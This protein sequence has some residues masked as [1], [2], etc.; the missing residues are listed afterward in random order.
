MASP[1]VR[2]ARPRGRSAS[3]LVLAVATVWIVW[4]STFLGIRVMVETIPPLLGSAVRFVLGG[5][6][7]ALVVVAVHGRGAFRLRADEW[8]GSAAM[9]LLLVAGGVGL[10]AL[11][12]HRGLPSSLAALIASSEAAMVLGLRIVAG[13]ERV[14]PATVVGVGVGVVGVVLLLSPG[15]RPAGVTLVAALLGLAGSITW[16]T[17]TWAGARIHTAPNLLANVAIQMLA[18]GAVLLVAGVV[19]GERFDAAAVSTRSLVALAGLTVASVAVY[20]AYAWL[21]RNAS[22]SLVTTQSYVNP[23][24]A[25]VLGVVVLH[26]T[27]GTVTA[28]GMAITLVAVVLVLRAERPDRPPWVPMDHARRVLRLPRRSAV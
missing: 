11:A 3:L 7:L 26:E 5:G 4:G 13:R 16:A 18:G 8:R 17:G 15:S 9:G 27:I 1:S 20:A 14:S 28:I 19:A 25:V 21:L 22:L 2:Q 10:V 6:A 12:E 23:V 24:V